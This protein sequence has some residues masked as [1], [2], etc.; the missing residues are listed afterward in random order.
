[1]SMNNG[2]F[3]NSSEYNST[4]EYRHFPAEMYIK[5]KEENKSGKELS[6]L[7]NEI[8]ALNRK[9]EK[10]KSDNSKSLIDKIFNS[11]KTVA[12]TA[13]VAVSAIVV[14]TTFVTNAPKVEL[15][16]LDC[17]DTYIEYEMNVSELQEEY[18]Y[19]LVISTSNEENIEIEINENGTYKNKVE[20][21]KPSWEYTLAFVCHDTSLGDVTHFE[22]RFQTEKY[23]QQ[24]PNPP[25]E[26]EPIP[27]PEDYTG[28]YNIKTVVANWQENKIV[29]PIEFENPNEQ[30]YYLI[31]LYDSNGNE[32]SSKKHM[33]NQSV[34]FTMVDGIDKYNLV[35]ELYGIGEIEER[36]IE[37]KEIVKLD[38]T[39]PSVDI[40]DA[41]IVGI[42]KI[43]I[44]FTT[45]NIK[46]NSNIEFIITHSENTIEDT[47]TLTSKDISNGYLLIDMDKGSTL[48]I[49]PI[50]YVKYEGSDSVRVIEYPK[51]EQ[52]FENTLIIDV[53]VGLYNAK[54]TFYPK[55]ITNG[56]TALKIIDSTSPDTENLENFFQEPFY[57]YYQSQGEITYTMY[58]TNDSDD[59]LSNEVVV[60]VDTSI[61]IPTPEYNMIYPSPNDVGITYNDDGTINM[62]I[63]TNF[64][65][66]SEETYYQ[67]KIDNNRYISRNNYL[68]ILSLPDKTYSLEYDICQNIN[69]V[70][71]SIFNYYPSGTI[72][73]NYLGNGYSATY[74]NESTLNLKFYLDNVYVDL[75]KVRIVSSSGEKITLTES[76]FTY[77]EESYSY[78]VSVAFTSPFE[79]VTIYIEAN[80]F[81]NGL[82]GIEKY[83][84]SLTKSYEITV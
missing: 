56:A 25:P 36:L 60:T 39:P 30:Y 4:S 77:N 18:D 17:K 80:C 35:F 54:N 63:K 72:N 5:P 7:G 14:T 3:Y 13:T 64:E 27:P 59:K 42:N 9:R 15:L 19:S 41:K 71:Y 43:Q 23:I 51:Y 49:K 8:T 6:S 26:P 79:H 69:G 22:V 55:G 62:Y 34:A 32:L 58:L 83:E 65:S 40:L 29:V 33:N 12:T 31:K 24:Q 38:Y 75:N 84:G 1:M 46:N 67:I 74:E 20:G 81:Y 52:A 10:P 44:D 53:T 68:E 57:T 82:N 28:T 11:I 73:E 16:S 45:D 61:D 70:Q 47:I 48:S 2:E 78:D 21:L 66:A 50:A 37:R 76:D